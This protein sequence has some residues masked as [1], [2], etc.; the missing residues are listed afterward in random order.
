[1][2]IGVGYKS[3]EVMTYL[4]IHLFFINVLTLVVF[5]WDKNLAIK[6]KPRISE[7]TLLWLAIIGGTFGAFLAIR[8]FKHKKRK[9][10]F[11]IRLIGV[12]V[13][14]VVVVAILMGLHNPS[15]L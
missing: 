1:L 6:N 11:L 9:K 13:F 12:V 2:G 3:I 14:Q 7:K 8:F 4:Y 5:G 10:S 15:L